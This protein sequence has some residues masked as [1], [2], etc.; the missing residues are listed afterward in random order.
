L[1]DF[2]VFKAYRGC[3]AVFWQGKVLGV[4]AKHL[5][6]QSKGIKG[7]ISLFLPLKNWILGEVGELEGF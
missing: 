6:G 5:E 2:S 7:S 1:I 4:P 3:F